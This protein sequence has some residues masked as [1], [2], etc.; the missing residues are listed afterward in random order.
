MDV[1]AEVH[2]II[3]Y[4]M[5]SPVFSP[6]DGGVDDVLLRLLLIKQT[7]KDVYLMCI[8]FSVKHPQIFGNRE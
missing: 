4:G 8:L 2:K 5:Y 1:S 7:A 6:S 3:K